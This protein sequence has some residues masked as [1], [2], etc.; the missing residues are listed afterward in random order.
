MGLLSQVL[1]I[2][3][4]AQNSRSVRKAVP[5]AG[6]A[7]RCRNVLSV[8]DGVLLHRWLALPWVVARQ[9]G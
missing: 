7:H 2:A 3:D 8:A 4:S 1:P 5:G 6:K 9:G